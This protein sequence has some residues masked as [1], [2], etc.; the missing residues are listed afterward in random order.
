MNKT[1][2][3]LIIEDDEASRRLLERSLSAYKALNLKVHSF[4]NAENGIASCKNYDY[5]LIITDYKL[6][7]MDGFEFIKEFRKLV[8]D[9][10]I[11]IIFLS[12]FF[13]E[14][15]MEN[16]KHHFENVMFLDK[17][18]DM[19]KLFSRISILLRISHYS[20]I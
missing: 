10:S 5:D 9:D 1:Y 18:F 13:K 14:L 7:G 11:P 3:L 20:N 17:P 19:E 4:V 16:N 15:K 6:P 8:G 12:G 2:Q